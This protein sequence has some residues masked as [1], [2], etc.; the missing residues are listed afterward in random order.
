MNETEQLLHQAIDL[1]ETLLIE[2]STG[3]GERLE[4][5]LNLFIK[6]TREH[7]NRVNRNRTIV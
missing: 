3:Y 6:K 7:E 5:E 2:N 4:D 1:L